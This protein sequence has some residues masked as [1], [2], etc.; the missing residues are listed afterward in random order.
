[1]FE[2]QRLHVMHV[3]RKGLAGGGMENGVINVTNGLP[4]GRFRISICALDFQE[5]FSERIRQP[6][7]AYYLLPKEGEGLQWS[8]VW[9]LARLF[10]H[11]RVDVVHSHNW[12]T[13]LYSVLAAKLARVPIIHGEHGKN[14]GEL[15]EVNR[16]KLLAK[17]LLGPRVDRLVTV[18]QAIAAEW[19]G[20]GVPKGKIEWIPNGVDLN[21]FQPRP[22]SAIL[23]REFGLSE[24]GLLIGSVGRFDPI[25]RYE[26]LIEAFAGLAARFPES[27]LA[28]LGDGPKEPELRALADGLGL[29]GRVVWLGRRP[30]PENFLPALDLFVLPSVSE[31]MSNVVLEAMACGLPVICADLPGHREVFQPGS[32]GMVVSPCDPPTLGAA[33]AELLENPKRRESLGAAA[34]KRAV[35]RFDLRRMVSD[36]ERLYDEY[37]RPR[38]LDAVPAEVQRG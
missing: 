4:A 31:G 28:L 26:V 2:P 34:R 6:D 16:P 20:H 14:L 25:K 33:L 10:R 29:S 30:N 32:E 8:L 11:T 37:A 19:A 5:T 38:R 24:T 18:S 1:M 13:F 22:A 36:Y 35:E 17:R 23:R 7:A 9:R 3:V 27:M 15:N 12:G 21:R